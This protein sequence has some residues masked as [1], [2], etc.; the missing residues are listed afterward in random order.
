VRTAKRLAE[1]LAAKGY[2]IVS[3]G[4]DNHLFLVDVTSKGHGGKEAEAVLDAVGITANKN[5]IPYD[6]RTPVDPSG[7]RL[8]TPTV[9]SRGMDVEAMDEVADL[10]DRALEAKA[11]EAAQAKVAAD[12]KALCKKYPLLD[13]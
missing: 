7:V 1:Q 12:V 5:M 9:A 13:Q 4:T 8:G 11:D 10:I 3:G 2:Q 6:E